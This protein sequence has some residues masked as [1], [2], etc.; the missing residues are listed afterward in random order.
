MTVTEQKTAKERKVKLS[1][2]TFQNAI[3]F[4]KQRK[5]DEPLIGCNRSTLY[6]DIRRA[7]DELGLQH[8][9][10]HSFRKMYAR[11]FARE[12]G[13]DAAQQELQHRYLSTTL[14]YLVDENALKKLLED[15]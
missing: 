6:R 2:A 3:R 12:R 9:S 4:A 13:V 8:V 15:D 14:L 10:M 7:A 11:R 5:P 1:A